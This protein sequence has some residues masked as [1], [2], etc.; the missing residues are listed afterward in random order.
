MAGK[1]HVPIAPDMSQQIKTAN[2]LSSTATSDAGQTYNTAQA[3]NQNAQDNLTKTLGSNNAAADSL[4]GQA[5]TNFGT[6]NS[7]FVPLQQE[8]AQQAQAWGSDANVQAQQGKAQADVNSAFNA[9]RANSAAALES[10]GVDPASIRGGALDAQSR[11]SQAAASAQAGTAARTNTI[12]QGQQLVANAN[13]LGMGVGNAGASEANAGAGI[14]TAD[15]N[16]VNSTNSN[17][18]NNLTAANTFLN[19]GINANNSAVQAQ[20]GQYGMNNEMYQNQNSQQASKNAGWGALV[21]SMSS[22]G[23][24][25]LMTGLEHGGVVGDGGVSAPT[26]GTGIPGRYQRGGVVSSYANGGAVSPA[27][28]LPFSP[29]PGSTDTKPALLTPDE[30]VLPKDVATWKGHAHW[31]KEIAKARE[32]RSQA[33]LMAIP[34]RKPQQAS[35]R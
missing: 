32:E 29:I 19:T 8:Q 26:I 31:Y 35:T 14:T 28:A 4:F 33:H 17:A 34:G 11:V 2:G 7:T 1:A 16:A 18:V 21:G 15:Q 30:F 12:M 24:L 23:P 9:Q 13:Q 10:E 22:G 20:E 5:N 25:G 3:Y 6:Y 27:G